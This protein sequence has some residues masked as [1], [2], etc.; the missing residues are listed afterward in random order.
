MQVSALSCIFWDGLKENL[1][2]FHGALGDYLSFRKKIEGHKWELCSQFTFIFSGFWLPDCPTF[3]NI[4]LVTWSHFLNQ[5]I[6]AMICP[7]K[8]FIFFI[9][10]IL[11]E[12]KNIIGVNI[13]QF[14]PGE[15]LLSGL[16]H[17]SNQQS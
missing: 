16:R 13:F 5:N 15:M 17:N 11:I 12:G 14:F 4:P 2:G 10:A 8:I 1:Q 9:K 3:E 7:Q 6:L